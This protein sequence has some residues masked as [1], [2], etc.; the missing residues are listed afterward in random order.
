[1]TLGVRTTEMPQTAILDD[2]LGTVDGSTVKL[3][4]ADLIKLIPGEINGP[5]VQT[6][7]EIKQSLDWTQGVTGLVYSGT[8]A[9]MYHKIGSQGDGSWQWYADLPF[10]AQTLVDAIAAKERAEKVSTGAKSALD[11]QQEMAELIE[12]LALDFANGVYNSA[13]NDPQFGKVD[14]YLTALRTGLA[15]GLQPTGEVAQFSEQECVMGV[16]DDVYGLVRTNNHKNFVM[17]S[18][19][20]KAWVDGANILSDP[21]LHIPGHELAKLSSSGYDYISTTLDTSKTWDANASLPIRILFAHGQGE[22]FRMILS[23]TSSGDVLD[24]KVSGKSVNVANASLGAISDLAISSHGLIR[25]LRF[26]LKLNTSFNGSDGEVQIGT[27][28][29]DSTAYTLFSG[30]EIGAGE[31]PF[32]PIVK[33]N[34]NFGVANRDTIS[35]NMDLIGELSADTY[36]S[37]EMDGKTWQQYYALE[38]ASDT[39]RA[40]FGTGYAGKSVFVKGGASDLFERVADEECDF[41]PFRGYFG[42][43]TGAARGGQPIYSIPPTD[44]YEFVP[45]SIFLGS[46]NSSV[47]GVITSL[48]L[49]RGR[50]DP[51]PKHILAGVDHSTTRV[52]RGEYSPMLTTQLASNRGD[53]QIQCFGE[54]FLQHVRVTA[55]EL[56]TP[57]DGDAEDDKIR[58]E[59]TLASDPPRNGMMHSIE[60]M[61]A[62]EPHVALSGDYP[63]FVF[64]QMHGG[65]DDAGK[66]WSP[67]LAMKVDTAAGKFSL[68]TR[69]SPQSVLSVNPDEVIEHEWDYTPWQAH[70]IILDWIDGGGT[71]DGLV[72]LYLNGEK[73]VESVKPTGYNTSGEAR[74]KWGVYAGRHPQGEYSMHMMKYRSQRDGTSFAD[75]P[76]PFLPASAKQFPITL[77]DQEWWS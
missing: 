39:Q 61:V 68:S 70:H 44:E 45:K 63:W 35:L 41:M 31:K 7:N 32:G 30:I 26:K 42:P 56:S 50:R 37:F 65:A 67:P 19:T 43:W 17:N 16:V 6:Y 46:E 53:K 3:P 59:F 2:L 36:L 13:F 51:S 33:T 54:G 29:A 10:T 1:M 27:G 34:T 18:H 77:A 73:V 47:D 25:E 11:D 12:C 72:R 14:D 55:D 75:S 48:K 74:C 66:H 57:L 24:I 38:M 4:L 40:L 76:R 60:F 49:Y 71:D 9:G 5:V 20:P 22:R 64:L 21:A 23:N 58:T 62:I 8:K 52:Q 69:T 15:Y 28:V